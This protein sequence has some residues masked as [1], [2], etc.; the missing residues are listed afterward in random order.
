MTR[1]G[2][3]PR[4]RQRLAALL[5]SAPRGATAARTPFVLLVVVLLGSGLIALLLLNSALN[6]GSFELSKLE[7]KTSELTDE[8]QALQ[9]E[10]DGYSAPDELAR[11]ARKLGMVPGGIPVFLLP[12]G[13]VRGKPGVA[14][15]EGA[16]LAAS[17]EPSPL[18]PSGGPP[19]PVPQAAPVPQ[20]APVSQAAPAPEAARMP[21]SP[22][23]PSTPGATASPGPMAT[24]VVPAAVLTDSPS[25]SASASRASG[26]SAALA[27]TTSG[28]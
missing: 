8:Q 20:T 21:L 28:R 6:Q 7:R 16:P 24:P 1:Q 18:G 2:G 12:D 14:A 27:P 26:R 13:T 15:S 22:L 4:G 23:A 3:R 25:P 10:V 17:A 5:P 11:R 9:Q 19:A